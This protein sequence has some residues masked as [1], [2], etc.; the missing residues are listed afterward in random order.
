MV[1]MGLTPSESLRACNF[2]CSKQKL[3]YEINRVALVTAIGSEA[4]EGVIKTELPVTINLED[5]TSQS[6]AGSSITNSSSSVSGNN[7]SWWNKCVKKGN[8]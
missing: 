1:R 7:D 4:R 6:L 3:S 2:P 5:K 8:L